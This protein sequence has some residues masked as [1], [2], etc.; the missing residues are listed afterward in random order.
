MFVGQK[1]KLQ[2]GRERRVS[3]HSTHPVP[4]ISVYFHKVNRGTTSVYMYVVYTYYCVP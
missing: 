3:L 1:S 2:K 4:L